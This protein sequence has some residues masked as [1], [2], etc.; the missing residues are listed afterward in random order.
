[1]NGEIHDSLPPS[2]R[3]AEMHVLGSVM[4]EPD[5]LDDIGG[6][7][8]AEHF[9]DHR[10]AMLYRHL[11]AMFERGR[12]IDIA[13][14]RARL[15]QSGDLVGPD[16]DKGDGLTFAYLGEIAQGV[17]Y[18]ANAGHYADLVVRT[19]QLRQLATI[20]R[21]LVQGAYGGTDEP[22]EILN[23][24]EAAL[25]A[26]ETGNGTDGPTSLWDCVSEANKRIDA[27]KKRG[28][29]AG[30][31]TGLSSFD[32][33]IGGLFPSELIILAARPG[34][35]KSALA[36]Q[37]AYHVASKGRTV[38]FASLEMSRLELTTRLMCS[39]SGVNGKAIRTGTLTDDDS[40]R[41]ANISSIAK[42]PMHI[43]DDTELSV[44]DIRRAA[45]RLKRSGLDLVVI[46]YLQLIRPEDFRVPRHEQVAQMSRRLKALSKELDVPVLCLC[47]LNRQAAN[48]KPELSHLRESGAIE[49]DADVVLLLHR[50]DTGPDES[51]KEN[52]AKD[53]EPKLIVAKN[54][55]GD[56]GGFPLEWVRSET[57][58]RTPGSEGHDEFAQHSNADRTG[59]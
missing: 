46:D 19:A 41:L 36:M 31:M 6:R 37:W 7:L 21:E 53:N 33:H 5:I 50:P 10:H 43:D 34:V 13:L 23:A 22:G 29:S 42:D 3:D 35:G 27:I 49:Q 9:Y 56:T 58:Y 38:Y 20:G 39:L 15:Q 45:R 4:L 32:G 44:Y 17:P 40:Q 14:L 47:Q 59:F 16:D 24:T 55:N 1:M 57:R 51:S 30:I 8:R 25:V 54:R 52:G 12:S 18:A 26:V 2:D 48:C 11:T 28:Q